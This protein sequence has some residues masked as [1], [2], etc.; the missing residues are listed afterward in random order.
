[1]TKTSQT[2]L[3]IA[4]L[5]IVSAV[6]GLSYLFNED[7]ASER[8]RGHRVPGPGHCKL[9]RE[10]QVCRVTGSSSRASRTVSLSDWHLP[11]YT[12]TAHV[13]LKDY[14][15]AAPMLEEALELNP[16]ETRYCLNS[17]WFISKLGNLSLSKAYFASVLEIDPSKR[18]SQRVNGH[19]GQPG[20]TT[21]RSSPGE[22]IRGR[23][24]RGRRS[25]AAISSSQLKRFSVFSRR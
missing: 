25:L 3:L 9:F 24:H 23:R 8:T 18:G 14:Q 20:T 4:G 2:Y 17:V 19:H 6:G 16:Q 10:R 11:Y 1:M 5:V 7:S 13:M 22:H 12:A 21:T 15:P